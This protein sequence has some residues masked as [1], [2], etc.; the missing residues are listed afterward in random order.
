M[1]PPDGCVP[2]PNGE[3]SEGSLRLTKRNRWPVRAWTNV[4]L[5]ASPRPRS[6]SRPGAERPR[7]RKLQVAVGHLDV[8]QER[9]RRGGVDQLV[10]GRHRTEGGGGAAPEEDLLEGAVGR[11]VLGRRR[12]SGSARRTT[13]RWPGPPSARR[14]PGPR[15]DRRAAAGCRGRPESGRRTGSAGR[16]GT[17]RRRCPPARRRPADATPPSQRSPRSSVSRSWGCQVSCTNAPSSWV[18]SCCPRELIG[19]DAG[20]GRRLQV[21]QHRAGHGPRRPG[22]PRARW[23]SRPSR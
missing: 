16:R 3:P 13:P 7:A 6:R 20:H 15:P 5:A 17:G 19:R 8:R 23:R 1:P 4:A 22:R 10:D 11:P 12:A 2:M 21:E 9:R 14:R 18:R